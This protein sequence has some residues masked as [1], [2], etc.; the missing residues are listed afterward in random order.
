LGWSIPTRP[1][2]PYPYRSE[3]LRPDAS[4][5]QPACTTDLDEITL[6]HALDSL[7]P[8]DRARQPERRESNLKMILALKDGPGSDEAVRALRAQ[9]NLPP[10]VIV[11]VAGAALDATDSSRRD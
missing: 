9:W 11:A 7:T 4:L 8:D 1:T 5:G 6:R 2:R 10:P 3:T